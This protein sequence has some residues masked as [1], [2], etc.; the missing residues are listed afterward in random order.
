MFVSFHVSLRLSLSLSFLVMS[1]IFNHRVHPVTLSN[2]NYITKTLLL[3]TIVR[4]SFHTL[5]PSQW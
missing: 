2:S 1:A 4:V 3:N 5:N